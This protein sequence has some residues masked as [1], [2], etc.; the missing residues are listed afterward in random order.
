MDPSCSTPVGGPLAAVPKRNQNPPTEDTSSSK[1]SVSLALQKQTPPTDDSSY[2]SSQSGDRPLSVVPRNKNTPTND[3]FFSSQSGDGRQPVVLQKQDTPILES[4]TDVGASLPAKQHPGGIRALIAEKKRLNKEWKASPFST[5]AKRPAPASEEPSSK[6]L[7]RDNSMELDELPGAGAEPFPFN[8][9]PKDIRPCPCFVKVTFPDGKVVSFGKVFEQSKGTEARVKITPGRY[10]D[11]HVILSM[12]VNKG[13]LEQGLANKE[14]EVSKLLMAWQPYIKTGD[15]YRVE[16]FTYGL[17][18]ESEDHC[19][20]AVV[21]QTKQANKDLSLVHHVKLVTNGF[22]VTKELEPP[23][24]DRLVDT[25]DAAANEMLLGARMM[26]TARDIENLTVEFWFGSRIGPKLWAPRVGALFKRCVDE[27]LP[28][29]HQ[30]Y[31][32]NEPVFDIDKAPTQMGIGAGMY[33]NKGKGKGKKLLPTDLHVFQP[34]T[35]FPDEAGSLLVYAQ[36]VIR[37]AHYRMGLTVPLE[38]EDCYF[39]LRSSKSAEI[40]EKILPGQS[41]RK[42]TPAAMTRD[43]FRACVRVP[44]LPQIWDESILPVGLKFKVAFSSERI[45]QGKVVIPE[46]RLK[47]DRL[48]LGEIVLPNSSDELNKTGTNF[49]ARL[50]KMP[51]AQRPLAKDIHETLEYLPNHHL[52]KG[53]IEVALDLK[54]EKQEVASLLACW[55]SQSQLLKTVRACITAEHPPTAGRS[56]DLTVC[57][58]SSVAFDF[59]NHVESLCNAPVKPLNSSQRRALMSLKEAEGRISVI[60]GAP[61]TGKTTV[62]VEAVRALLLAGHKVHVAGPTHVSIDNVCDQIFNKMKDTGKKVLRLE[63]DQVNEIDILQ[64]LDGQ[65]ASGIMNDPKIAEAINIFLKLEHGPELDARMDEVRTLEGEDLALTT[66][67]RREKRYDPQ[68]GQV[69]HLGDALYQDYVDAWEL[70]KPTVPPPPKEEVRE[71]EYAHMKGSRSKHYWDL[72]LRIRKLRGAAPDGRLAHEWRDERLRQLSRVIAAADCV[73][74]T[75]YRSGK[76]IAIAGFKATILVCEEAGQMT[77]PAMCVALATHRDTLQGLIVIGDHW[78]LKPVRIEGLFNEFGPNMRISFIEFLVDKGR[79][80][81]MLTISYQF[82]QLLCRL[83][84][85]LWYESKLGSDPSTEQDNESRKA[86]R[87]VNLALGSVVPAEFVLLDVYKG[88]ARP[89]I[90]GGTSLQN[91]ANANAVADVVAFYLDNGVE[92]GQIAILTMYKAQQAITKRKLVE[93]S[94]D[95]GLP[96]KLRAISTIDAFQGQQSPIVILDLVIANRSGAGPG[97]GATQNVSKYTQ[98]A[99]RINVGLTRCQFALTVVCHVQRIKDTA[100]DAK[101]AP[102]IE[103][104]ALAALVQD[105]EECG[106]IVPYPAADDHPSAGQEA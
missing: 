64:G 9:I 1:R 18:S 93:Q 82:H 34:M 14:D 71:L 57:H 38:A 54:N 35:H 3:V 52:I 50:T 67:G 100:Y 12:A 36:G 30:Y 45:Y 5:V 21:E 91:F 26:S 101:A 16:E 22:L 92:P 75:T 70:W 51:R 20:P 27:R 31:Q 41:H 49:V 97:S 98:E 68:A 42:K 74:A 23:Y 76:E 87:A 95:N 104:S 83:P 37:A 6:R 2:G 28:W 72:V 59:D 73:L 80:T 69:H 56:H 85:W 84:S 19:N 24:W 25:G 96:G 62:C 66:R 94:G 17:A 99:N 106:F 44:Y 33:V 53:Q 63:V 8:E 55:S 58:G 78:Q 32:N 89:D 102:G 103:H 65:S 43:T 7:Q 105:A 90:L 4:T 61:G 79:E 48:Y 46:Q 13:S 10:G 40:I 15:S 29:Y 86:A 81:S 11:P 88:I 60:R 47:D 77:I 39:F